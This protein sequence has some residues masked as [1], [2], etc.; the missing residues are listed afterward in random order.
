MTTAHYHQLSIAAV[1]PE[2]DAAIAVDLAIPP[3]H[4]E[5]FRYK[6]GQHL[7]VRVVLD[8]QEVRRTYSICS[9]PGDDTLTIAI[10]RVK[11]GWLSNWANDT[12]KAGDTIEAM[13]PAGRFV[14][15][16]GTG[17]PRHVLAIAA[18]AGITPVI[19]MLKHILAGESETGVTLVYGNRYLEQA[20]FLAEIEDLKDRYLGRLGVF[21]VLS[22]RDA[23]EVPLLSGRIDGARL[24]ALAKVLLA[25]DELVS[26]TVR[27]VACGPGSMIKEARDTLL[28]LGLPRDC[29]QYEFFMVGPPGARPAAAPSATGTVEARAKAVAEAVAILDGKRH[30]FG[31]QEGESI[32]DAA[33]RAGLKVPYSCKGGMCCTCRAKLVEGRASMTAN[34]SLEPWETGQGFVLTC[35][36]RPETAQVVVDYDQM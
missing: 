35:Q 29:F 10:K 24:E 4:A 1:R 23:G 19:S 17:A 20:I 34:Y 2:T 14:V 12:L 22:G 7:P 30:T 32:V 31:V 25:P 9:G 21:H 16:A 11:D 13:P 33:L 27:V 15:P 5:T 36:A 3:E 26:G 28:R 8:G 6:P 18:G